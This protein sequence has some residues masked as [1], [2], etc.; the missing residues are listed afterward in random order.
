MFS[1]NFLGRL[2]KF[3]TYPYSK[4]KFLVSFNCKS[5]LRGYASKK[6]TSIS[7]AKKAPLKSLKKDLTNKVAKPA[8]EKSKAFMARTFGKENVAINPVISSKPFAN[9]LKSKPEKISAYE[10][11][12]EFFSHPMTWDRNNGYLNILLAIAIFGY[13]FCSTCGGEKG[14]STG[15]GGK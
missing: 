1:S 4:V 9:V 8:K 6:I 2:T 7:A 13:S 5:S 14:V 15:H 10:G 11:F 12:K 3:Y